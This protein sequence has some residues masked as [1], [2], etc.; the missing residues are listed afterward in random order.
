VR[1]R[2][3]AEQKDRLDAAAAVVQGNRNLSFVSQD[4]ISSGRE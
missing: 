4:W 1:V 2:F 3:T